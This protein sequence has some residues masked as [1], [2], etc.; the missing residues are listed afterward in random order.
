MTLCIPHCYRLGDN[1]VI[2]KYYLRYIQHCRRHVV[3]ETNQTIVTDT[4]GVIKR[5]YSLFLKCL[6]LKNKECC[7]SYLL[8]NVQV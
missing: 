5:L 6:R 8:F 7:K 3:I 4:V 2:S 1:G